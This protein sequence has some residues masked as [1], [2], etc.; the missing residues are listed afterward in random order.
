[1][2][3]LPEAPP[4]L[5]RGEEMKII[6]HQSKDEMKRYTDNRKHGKPT[7]LVPNDQLLVHKDPTRGKQKPTMRYALTQLLT[8]K[9]L[10]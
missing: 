10:W 3:K 9:D 2:K 8:R 6:D 1:M 7:N 4:S 5:S